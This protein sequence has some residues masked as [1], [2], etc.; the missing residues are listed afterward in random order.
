M[1]NV[2]CCGHGGTNGGLVPVTP[3]VMASGVTVTVKRRWAVIKL[4]RTVAPCHCTLLLRY[5]NDQQFGFCSTTFQGGGIEGDGEKVC[6]VK[7]S[8]YYPARSQAWI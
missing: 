6:D 7:T 1:D 2:S 3:A 4:V 8:P 5:Q